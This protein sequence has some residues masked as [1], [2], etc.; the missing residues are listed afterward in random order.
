MYTTKTL[1]AARRPRLPAAQPPMQS[2]PSKPGEAD[3]RVRE[4]LERM[5]EFLRR[6]R[7]KEG[8]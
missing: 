3:Q 2:H 7:E 4:D 8:G 6:E 1:P 5:R